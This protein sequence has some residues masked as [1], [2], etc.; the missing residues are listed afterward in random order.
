MIELLCKRILKFQCFLNIMHMKK[1]KKKKKKK[2]NKSTFVTLH[3]PTHI[4]NSV[5]FVSLTQEHL[6]EVD[7]LP[8]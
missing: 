4:V 6:E 2:K 7:R 3:S 1:K 8:L 5:W